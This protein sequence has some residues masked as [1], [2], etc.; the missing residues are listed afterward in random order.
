MIPAIIPEFIEQLKV[1]NSREWFSENKPFYQDAQKAFEDVTEHLIRLVAE[2]D[3]ELG[4]PGVKDCIFRIYRDT[5]F[6][7]DKTPYKEHFGTFVANGGRKS[8]LGGYY[9]HIQPGE[10]FFAGGIY[11]PMPPVLKALRQEV[12]HFPDEFLSIVQK[13]SF[14]KTFGELFDE[15][16]KMAPKGFPKDF[17]HIELLKY[18][19]YIVSHTLSDADIRSSDLEAKLKQ[20]I[21]EVYPLNA[22]LNRG[23]NHQ[24]DEVDL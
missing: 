7:K 20:L 12:Y 16:L 10:S 5:R 23:V 11:R 15:R 17:E 6:S 19:S 14:E 13:P 8:Q 18:K 21:R 24:E 22:F 1:N 3:K 4:N 9:L 2:V